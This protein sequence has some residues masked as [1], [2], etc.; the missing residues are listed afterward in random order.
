MTN[1]CI[2][3]APCSWG[4]LEFEGLEG[5]SIGYSQMLDELA[6]TGYQGTE[7]GDWGFMPTNSDEL[8]QELK[9]RNL[10]LLGG[11]VPVALRYPEQH[12]PGLVNALKTANLMAEVHQ[13]G[14]SKTAPFLV[15]SDENGANPK[16]TLNAGRITPE[17]SLSQAEWKSFSD[18]ASQIAKQVKKQTGLRTVFHHH[19]SGFIET[20][21]EIEQLLDLTDPEVLGLV[22]DTGHYI[23]GSGHEGEETITQGLNRF[24]DR[25]WYIH[26][27]DCHPKIAQASREEERDYFEAVKHGVFCE[28]GQGGVDFKAVKNWLESQHYSGWALVEQDV[29]PGMGSPKANAR[30]NLEYLRSIGF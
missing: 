5:G 21:N 28:L 25:I 6:E 15:L 19:C 17:L 29:L 13:K 16:R 22:F 20:P 9:H 2:G 18:G 30:R 24:A 7:L 4:S 11:F 26:F 3:N 10:T 23:Y 27:K 12:A 8:R 14:E 1:I